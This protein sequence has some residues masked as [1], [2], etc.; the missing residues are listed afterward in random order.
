[1]TTDHLPPSKVVSFQQS[2]VNLSPLSFPLHWQSIDYDIKS[3]AK[4]KLCSRKYIMKDT[5]T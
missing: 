4:P 1:M 3:I 5:S 2:F